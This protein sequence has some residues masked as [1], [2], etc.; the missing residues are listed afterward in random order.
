MDGG[1]SGATALSLSFRPFADVEA[2]P[3]VLA[4]EDF[5]GRGSGRFGDGTLGSLRPPGSASE[6][7]GTLSARDAFPPDALPFSESAL[8]PDPVRGTAASP[9]SGP[10]A[11]VSGSR[12]SLRSHMS[13]QLA[14]SFFPG[15][16]R[17]ASAY[18]SRAVSYSSS[19]YAAR[20]RAAAAAGSWG[21]RVDAL[22]ASAADPS[23]SP[24]RNRAV[25]RPKS[26]RTDEGEPTKTCAERWGRGGG[27]GGGG[28]CAR[29][30]PESRRWAGGEREEGRA[31]T[32]RGL[33]KGRKVARTDAQLATPGCNRA[34]ACAHDA[35]IVR[36][37]RAHRW[38]PSGSAFAGPIGSSVRPASRPRF[39]TTPIRSR[40][41]RPPSPWL[42]GRPRCRRR[43]RVASPPP[44][45]ARRSSKVLPRRLR[46][47]SLCERILTAR[48]RPPLVRAPRKRRAPQ[49]Q[50]PWP[51]GPPRR[52]PETPRPPSRTPRRKESSPDGNRRARARG[53]RCARVAARATASC[54]RPSCSGVGALGGA[55][56]RSS[57]TA[58]A[59]DEVPSS[60]ADATVRFCGELPAA[61]GVRSRARRG[62][63]GEEGGGGREG[64]G[65]WRPPRCSARARNSHLSLLP[66]PASS[67]P[68]A[69]PRPPERARA[70]AREPAPA[71]TRDSDCAPRAHPRDFNG[72]RVHQ[73]H[74]SVTERPGSANRKS[75]AR[76]LAARPAAPVPRPGR[77]A[78]AA[79]STLRPRPRA[80]MRR[81]AA[82]AGGEPGGARDAPAVLPMSPPTPQRGGPLIGAVDG[83]RDVARPSP[84]DGVV[85]RGKGDSEDGAES[86]AGPR[87]S[88]AAS[89]TPSTSSC[90]SFFS[91]ASDESLSRTE[92]PLLAALAPPSPR[93]ALIAPLP[94]PKDPPDAITFR[95]AKTLL[96]TADLS[97]LPEAVG[98]GI[99]ALRTV[100]P[101]GE[102]ASVGRHGRPIGQATM[103]VRRLA[104]VRAPP[105]RVPRGPRFASSSFHH[106]VPPARRSCC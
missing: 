101:T 19:A 30:W 57:K 75:D 32:G 106:V 25:A 31:R 96:T 58:H 37:K 21:A 79:G 78:A 66:P 92:D 89:T 82:A 59:T 60:L 41:D 105:P 15:S 98:V 26:A 86:S 67:P 38:T 7:A 8:R 54:A 16:R 52:R 83:A 47:A 69:A 84:S 18:A 12:P 80:R 14:C 91:F 102:K 64:A 62:A 10:S 87:G 44:A 94:H 56:A 3:E 50:S 77:Q 72:Y 76:P 35:T 43:V 88:S 11:S 95:A 42:G 99:L 34:E 65:R 48:A 36:R 27:G 85:S 9:A 63:G 39:P 53:E 103:P 5:D 97:N 33:S 100:R 40:S 73:W 74:S 49:P 29:G 1:E 90:G 55:P 13:R 2:P 81:I 20:P 28:R 93:A 70:H 104:F 22:E 17:A 45:P 4:G 68:P 24:R 71:G 6:P 23:R 61:L 51:S 46:P